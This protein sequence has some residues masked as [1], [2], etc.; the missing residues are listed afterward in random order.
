MSECG[1][2]FKSFNSFPIIL[3]NIGLLISLFLFRYSK[4]TAFINSAFGFGFNNN[5]SGD[6]AAF[7]A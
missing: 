3:I 6:A 1:N 4:K 5:N 2:S 7:Q